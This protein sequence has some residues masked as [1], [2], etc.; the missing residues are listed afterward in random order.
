MGLD[1]KT[2]AQVLVSIVA[3]GLFVSGLVILSL[4]YGTEKDTGSIEI[5][6]E[7]GLMLVGLIALFIIAMPIF[8]YILEQ[9]DF[10]SE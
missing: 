5:A 9:R 1:R 6:P 2:I 4:T 7:G 10:E 8:G 3:V